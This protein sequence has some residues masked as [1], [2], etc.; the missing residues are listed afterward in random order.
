M[1]WF[2]LLLAVALILVW[3]V[4]RR[5]PEAGRLLGIALAVVA[6]AAGGF[7]LIRQ[8][9]GARPGN[10]TSRE[11]LGGLV[12]GRRVAADFPQGG[13]LL[14]LRL[15]PAAPDTKESSACRLRG[16]RQALKGAAWKIVQLG[17][18]QP[19]ATS[20]D[21]GV[22][23][24]PA[25][26]LPAEIAARC[27][28]DPDTRAVVSLLGELP[29]LAAAG[30]GLP[31]CYAF[32]AGRSP[33]IAQQLLQQG[34]LKALVRY[35]GFGPPPP[36]ASSFPSEDELFRRDFELVTPEGAAPSAPGRAR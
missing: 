1:Y 24:V 18:E 4:Q 32:D 30:A 36:A 20:A 28:K 6:I 35:R 5:N 10:W 16:L 33:E 14:V 13:S 7:Q 8:A 15:P 31:P 34:R 25:A 27:A 19:D 29:D 9:R 3:R 22:N 12:L 21:P 2:L 11:E 26:K 23:V 17:P